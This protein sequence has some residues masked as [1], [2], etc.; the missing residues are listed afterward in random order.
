MPR[1]PAGVTGGVATKAAVDQPRVAS[2]GVLRCLEIRCGSPEGVRQGTRGPAGG[3]RQ[4]CAATPGI[5]QGSPEGVC[6]D[7]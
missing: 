4:G 2:R 6:R 7:T 3:R 5:C 1:G